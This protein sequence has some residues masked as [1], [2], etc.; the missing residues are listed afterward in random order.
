MCEIYWKKARFDHFNWSEIPK[1]SL[2]IMVVNIQVSSKN[3][4]SYPSGTTGPKLM[5]L[6]PYKKSLK[7]EIF[8][9]IV[10][11]FLEVVWSAL[12]E[13]LSGRWSTKYSRGLHSRLMVQRFLCWDYYTYFFHSQALNIFFLN[14]AIMWEEVISHKI[15]QVL[16]LFC[17]H[18]CRLCS[19][20]MFFYWLKFL[21]VSSL[22][23][24]IIPPKVLQECT[25]ILELKVHNVYV[26]QKLV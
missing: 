20:F 18:L 2:S 25:T 26:V 15:I 19:R 13:L 7:W 3:I 16:F 9:S 17:C 6:L 22:V 5:I 8:V 23:I 21:L 10:S 12:F 4:S 14:T 11:T 24:Q 1:F